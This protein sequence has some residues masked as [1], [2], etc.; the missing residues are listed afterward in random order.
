MLLFAVGDV[1]KVHY[2]TAIPLLF[3]CHSSPLQLATDGA[4]IR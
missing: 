1:L 3:L 2:A 4:L